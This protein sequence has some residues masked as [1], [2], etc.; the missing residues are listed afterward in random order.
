VPRVGIVTDSTADLPA[1]LAQDGSVTVVPLVVSWDNDTFRDKVDLSIDEFYRRLGTSRSLPKTGAPSLAAFEDAFRRQLETHEAV[2]SVNLPGTLSTTIS[3]AR[4]AAEAVDPRRITVVDAGNVTLCQG[5][6]IEAAARLASEGAGAE[7]IAAAL[8]AMRP[9]LRLF[10][11]LSTLEFLQRGGRIG[12]A[13]ALAGTLLNVKPILEVREGEV[14]PVERVRTLNAAIRRLVE[15]IVGVG[16]IERL[17]VLHGAAGDSAHELER[18]LQPHFP[19]V[20]IE[21]GEIGAVLGVHA[22]P[23]VFG[24]ALLLAG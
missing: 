8:A 23:G 17:A 15:L 20:P 5:W 11:I 22:G 16:P 14:R 10:A 2:V 7:D 12:R 1:S 3:V 9:R 18:Q 21:H 4:Q 6:L 19:N 13:A 24:T